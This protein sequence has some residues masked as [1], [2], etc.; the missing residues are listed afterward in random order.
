MPFQTLINGKPGDT[1]PVTDRGLAYGDGLFETCRVVDNQL[2]FAELHWRRL[3]DSASRLGIVLPFDAGVFRQSLLRVVPGS[4]LAKLIVTRGSGGRGY[5]VPERQ[6][7]RWLVQG[8]PVPVTPAHYYTRGVTVRSCNIK[9]ASQ[10]VLAGMKHLNRLEQ[11]LARNEWTDPDI[12]E[13]LLFSQDRLLI[14]GT[15]SNLFL[16]KGDIWY[17]PR[18]DTSGVAGVMRAFILQYCQQ[19]HLFVE[20]SVL[21]A[22]DLMQSEAAFLCNSVRG[23]IPIRTWLEN[24]QIRKQWDIAGQL[25]E[26]IS[27][28][29]RQSGLP[30][31]AQAV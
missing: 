19:N 4:G 6:E 12:F 10:P 20:E 8:M 24:N 1:L 14:E 30:D 29:H 23:V 22:D 27:S 13:G 26:L 31:P 7:V 21:T 9:L 28:L 25:I 17:T 18:L 2:M 15:V 11:I 3:S 16:L 5:A